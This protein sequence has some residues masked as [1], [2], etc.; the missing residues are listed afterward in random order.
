M[1]GVLEVS[2]QAV[3]TAM[4]F[5]YSADVE[6]LNRGTELP[7]NNDPHVHAAGS[8]VSAAPRSSSES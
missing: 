2:N 7:V 3:D 1:R 4:L 5:A 8:T 6:L